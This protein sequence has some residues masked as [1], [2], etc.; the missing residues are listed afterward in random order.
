MKCNG[1]DELGLNGGSILDKIKRKEIELI[2]SL[3][4]SQTASEVSSSNTSGMPE[5]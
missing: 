3:Q 2:Y 5:E 1:D 4:E